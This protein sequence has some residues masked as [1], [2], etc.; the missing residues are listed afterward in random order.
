MRLRIK[1]FFDN[2]KGMNVY[3][4]SDPHLSTVVNKPMT[5]FG[6]HWNNYWDIITKDW[7]EKVKDEDIVI[8]SGD[9]SWGISLEEAKPDIDLI[10][11]LPGKIVIGKGNHDYWWPS[12]NKLKTFLPSNMYPQFSNCLRFDNILIC[13]SR[14]WNIGPNATAEDKRILEKHEIPRLL[15]SLDE[16]QKERKEGDIV[17]AM[18]HF[19]PFDLQRNESIFTKIF[20][21][22]KVDKVVYGHLHGDIYKPKDPHC[23]ING[24]DYYLTACDQVNHKLVKII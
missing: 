11:A 1:F 16:M 23:V 9:I 14:L 15:K 20:E 2:V 4:I 8:V 17:I 13:G 21:E 6:E 18:T 10:A 3:A 24:I 19:P 12:L 5:I 7:K 22:Y